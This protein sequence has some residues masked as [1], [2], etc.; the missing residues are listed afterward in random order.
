MSSIDILI[1]SVLAF[2]MTAVGLSLTKRHFLVLL[3]RPKSLFLGLGL[4]II[5]L[6]V[7]AFIVTS[8]W[9]LPPEF[10]VGVIILAACPGGMTSNFISFFMKANTALAVS[11]TICNSTITMLSVPFYVGLALTTHLGE[12]TSLSLPFWSAAGKI[13]LVVLVPVW[14]GITIRAY[15]PKTAVRL[16]RLLRGVSIILLGLLFLIKFFAPTESGGSG[17]TLQEIGLILPVS[18]LINFLALSSGYTIARLFGRPVNDQVTLGVEVGIQN[19][20]LAFLIAATLLGNDNL[21]K[22]ALVYAMFSFFTALAYASILKP[23]ELKKA[24]FF[25]RREEGK[26]PES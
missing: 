16:Q 18:L 3:S 1:S 22:P 9:N 7:L 25:W 6:P 24:V 17:I 23:G 11:L 15:F 12:T 26:Q 13:F 2:I 14:I 5:I 8:F 20:N 10:A 4:Q 19:T 21:L